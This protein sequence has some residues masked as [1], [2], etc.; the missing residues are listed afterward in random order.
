LKNYYGKTLVS[1][2]KE[3]GIVGNDVTEG[4]AL[5][6]SIVST[7]AVVVPVGAALVIAFASCM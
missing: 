4:A 3:K 7:N 6:D 1:R 5:E 2:Y